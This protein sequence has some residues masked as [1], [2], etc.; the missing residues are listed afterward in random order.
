MSNELQIGVAELQVGVADLQVGV[1]ASKKTLDTRQYL[2]RDKNTYVKIVIK[3]TY[4]NFTS[5]LRPVTRITVVCS[6]YERLVREHL[7]FS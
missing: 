6:T 5:L 7:F 2:H 3:R 4:K 1:A